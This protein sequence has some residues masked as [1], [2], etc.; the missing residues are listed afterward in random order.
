MKT[1]IATFVCVI[2]V[3]L[4]NTSCQRASGIQAKPSS[5]EQSGQKP[6]VDSGQARKLEAEKSVAKL[7]AAA[8]AEFSRGKYQA[9]LAKAEKICELQPDTLQHQFFRGNV[10]FA[11][12][13]MTQ[14]VAAF[15]EVIRLSPASKPQLWQRGLSLYYASRFADGVKQ[16]E[17][18]QTVN[19]QDVENAV[20]HLLCAARV[21]DVDQART[22]L[23]PITGDTRVPMSQVYEMFAGRMTPAEVL[24]A[25]SKTTH[26]IQEGDSQHRLQQYY[27]HLY[28][29][30]FYEMQEKPVEAK[31]SMERALKFNPLPK[32][33]FMGVVADVHL[34]VRASQAKSAETKK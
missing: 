22:K 15:D 26:R 11:A 1:K 12:G 31:A 18:H 19:S 27:A 9:A 24:K 20:W 10:S 2:V 33:N 3:L 25:A 7:A 16:F 30:L 13:D 32:D 28:I 5:A 23:I 6:E 8:S 14:S 4:V 34:R 17:T 29:G 21:S